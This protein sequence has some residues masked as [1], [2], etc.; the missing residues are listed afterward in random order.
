MQALQRRSSI[1]V[2]V[3]VA[4]SIAASA[5]SRREYPAYSLVDILVWGADLP[6]DLSRYA[7][8]VR[9]EI[10]QMRQR[11]AAY[12]SRRVA[13]SGS[14]ELSMVHSAWVHY[15]RRL[16]AAS[17]LPGADALALAYVTELRPCYEWEGSSECPEREAVFAAQYQ[18]KH[19]SGPFSDYL[20]LLESHRWLCAA[21]AYVFEKAPGEAA[22]AR[23][24][25]EHALTIARRSLSLLVRTAAGELA[26]RGRCSVERR[27]THDANRPWRP[28]TG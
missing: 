1:G 27:S 14:A 13:P 11:S 15:E 19:P 23:R 21:E 24:Q 9:T 25:H 26:A 16:V 28:R 8:N 10:E 7:P 5:Q 12:R 6:S 20:P 2:A 3:L 4:C 17:T 18:A 22:R